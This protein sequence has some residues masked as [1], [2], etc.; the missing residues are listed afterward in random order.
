MTSD[1]IRAADWILQNKDEYNIRVANFSLQT[2]A[3]DV[4]PLRPA[5]PRGRAALASGVV[6]VAAAGNYGVDGAPSGV[7]FSPGNDPF[8]ITVGAVD[9]DGDT[10]TGNDFNAPWSAYGYTLDGFAKPELGAPGRY[11]IER[12]PPDATPRGRAPGRPCVRDGMELSGTSFAAPVVSGIAADLLGM[13]PD[14]TPDQVK[15]ALMRSATALK[16]GGSAV[17]RRRRGQHQ[18]GDRR[19]TRAAEPE[20]GARSVPRARSG[21]RAATRSSTRRAGSR[22]RK[23]SASWNSASWV[24]ASW[25][26]ASWNT[27]LLE[28]RL[29]EQRLVPERVLEHARP[30]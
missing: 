4:V 9:I 30:G 7:L 16:R 22:R 17:R 6:V 24:S 23:D 28:Q 8:V 27:R 19:Q 26:T 18:E 15:G 21:R 11:M 29:V 5:R 13:H 10:G 20:R 2:G 14:W 25:N 1:V 12:V 3:R